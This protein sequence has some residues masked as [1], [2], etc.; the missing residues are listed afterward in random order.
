ML[1]VCLFYQ[2]KEL[3][4]KETDKI[5]EYIFDKIEPNKERDKKNRQIHF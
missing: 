1:F 2:T 5:D 4:R 3:I